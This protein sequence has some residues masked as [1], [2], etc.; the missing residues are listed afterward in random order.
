MIGFALNRWTLLMLAVMFVLAHAGAA[1]Q[2]ASRDSAAPDQAPYC[3]ELRQVVAVAATKERFSP[4]VGS[5]RE[6]EF[7]DA[8]V[9]LPGWKDCAIYG[10]RMYTCDSEQVGTSAAVEIMLAKTVGQVRAC[11]G[12][13]WSEVRERSSATYVVLHGAGALS[14]TLSTDR[15]D[16]EAFIVRLT[17]FS[18]AP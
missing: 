12:E 11:L 1:G 18:R 7:T 4:I 13:R 2:D 8:R 10:S 5:P 14:L 17:L 15:I 16:R 6:G 3:G 9:P